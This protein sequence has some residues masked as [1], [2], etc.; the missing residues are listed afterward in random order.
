ML[1]VFDIM[2]IAKKHQV[3]TLRELSKV[4][5]QDCLLSQLTDGFLAYVCGLNV[6]KIC[7]QILKEYNRLRLLQVKIKLYK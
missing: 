4:V 6:A 2:L 1:T 3:K 7:P 5:L